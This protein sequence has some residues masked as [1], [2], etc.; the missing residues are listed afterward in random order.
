LRI[1]LAA[2]GQRSAF[3]RQLLNQDSEHAFD[4]DSLIGE[5][6]MVVG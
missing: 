2:C 5:L 4:L 3:S 1:E 6:F